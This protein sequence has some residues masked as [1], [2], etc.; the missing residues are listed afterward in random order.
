MGRFILVDLRPYVTKAPVQPLYYPA[1]IQQRLGHLIQLVWFHG[2]MYPGPARRP[3]SHYFTMNANDCLIA[4]Q[5]IFHA[6]EEG[7]EA[8]TVAIP[9]LLDEDSVDRGAKYRDS[10]LLTALHQASGELLDIIQGRKN[11]I[12]WT[13]FMLHWE[14]L[15]DTTVSQK[16]LLYAYD[17]SAD[18]DFPLFPAND[19]TALL[20]VRNFETIARETAGA[21]GVHIAVV[22]EVAGVF[23]RTVAARHHLGLPPSNDQLILLLSYH[24]YIPLDSDFRRSLSATQRDALDGR[25]ARNT[26]DYEQVQKAFNGRLALKRSIQMHLGDTFT[27]AASPIHAEL[28]NGQP[29]L[30]PP[31]RTPT[32]YSFESLPPLPHE[33]REI[34]LY[35]G[36]PQPKPRPKPVGTTP[37]AP[38][39][40]PVTLVHSSP[41]WVLL[42]PLPQGQQ[43]VPRGSNDEPIHGP[44]STPGSQGKKEQ[45]AEDDK[46]NTKPAGK[47]A[48]GDARVVGTR[49]LRAR[50]STGV[51][52][53]RKRAGAPSEETR[54]TKK[55][56]VAD[57]YIDVLEDAEGNRY[58]VLDDEKS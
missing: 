19:A 48:K 5:S 26:S 35:D 41:V 43:P 25:L 20:F 37:K 17:F 57:R 21:S 29:F 1:K 44:S 6:R 28:H 42:V 4:H 32:P 15:P 30:F 24:R 18:F 54:S 23:F 7:S 27:T 22:H 51:A 16:Q 49:T 3:T 45:T 40:P 12:L 14:R 39:P 52:V 2:N 8:G 55:R 33:F 9:P 46:N 58:P 31:G 11:H 38:A 10:S 53:T 50:D 34:K 13:L 47:K 36:P 56:K